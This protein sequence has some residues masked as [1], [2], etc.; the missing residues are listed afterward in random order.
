MTAALEAGKLPPKPLMDIMHEVCRSCKDKNVRIL[1]DAESQHYQ[2]GIFAVGMEL[3][4]EY[5]RDGYATVYNT[6]QAYLKNTPDTISKH[7]AE[8]AEGGFSLGL[9]LVRGAYMATDERGLIHDTKEDTDNAYNNISQAIIKRQFGGFGTEGVPFPV[10]DLFLASHNSASLFAA[11]KTHQSRAVHGLPTVRLD[12]GQLQG[13]SDTLSLG[14]IQGKVEGP[15]VAPNV[16]KCSTWGTMRE[17]LAYLMRRAAE[18]KDAVTRTT[19]EYAAL[20]REVWRRLGF[21]S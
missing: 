8:A 2:S 11:Q 13:M 21:S 16:Y 3:A 17:C 4:R 1:I 6:Y 14:L 9:K 19:D 7:I 10:V 15:G 18:N 20:K 12:F 5:N